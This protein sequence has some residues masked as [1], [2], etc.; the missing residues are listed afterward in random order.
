MS[1]DIFDTLTTCQ[2]HLPRAGCPCYR[3]DAGVEL[4]LRDYL[5]ELVRTT[6]PADDWSWGIGA[7]SVRYSLGVSEYFKFLRESF[8]LS[9]TLGF[10]E[11]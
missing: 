2:S 7:G 1:C 9:V 5:L 10:P 3:V 8:E 6:Y 11:H 4:C